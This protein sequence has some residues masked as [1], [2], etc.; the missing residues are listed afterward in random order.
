[1]AIDCP[2]SW[3]RHPTTHTTE[4]LTSP[5]AQPTESSNS[6]DTQ[7]AET[8]AS[9]DNAPVDATPRPSAAPVEMDTAALEGDSTAPSATPVSAD[10]QENIEQPCRLVDSQGLLIQPN[11]E[12]AVADTQVKANVD[13][14][15]M[16]DTLNVDTVHMAAAAAMKKAYKI[17]QKKAGRRLPAKVGE[18]PG[19]IST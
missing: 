12:I 17:L 13:E 6:S 5:D 9:A 10:A 2:Y 7:H 16:G 11:K 15:E 3:N 4:D 18:S 1:M 14:D 8:D 19:P